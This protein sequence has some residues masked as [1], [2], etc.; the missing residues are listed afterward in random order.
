MG[1]MKIP[2]KTAPRAKQA[3]QTIRK[4]NIQMKTKGIQ[5]MRLLQVYEI[6]LLD[7]F[8]G[9]RHFVVPITARAEKAI[10]M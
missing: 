8:H 7:L 9:R 3:A 10:K 4:S 6:R 2:V 1:T 5:L